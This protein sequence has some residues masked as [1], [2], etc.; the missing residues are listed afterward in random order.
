MKELIKSVL[1][2]T[3]YK[4]VRR[5]SATH[6]GGPPFD[7]EAHNSV[8][9]VNR[10]FSDKARLERY[11][12][13]GRRRLYQGTKALMV[14]ARP[15]STCRTV[16]DFGCGPGAFFTTFAPEFDHCELY[17]YDFAEATLAAAR[18]LCPRGVYEEY[19]IYTPPP[20]TH[21]MVVASQ[22]LEH[23]LEPELALRHLMAATAPGGVLV[24]TVPD[25]RIDT[26]RGHIHFWSPESWRAWI[27]RHVPG[28]HQTTTIAGGTMGGANLA[29]VIRL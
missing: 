18:T 13:P 6:G 24:L 25:G 22:I 11:V 19:D 16:G 29:A 5:E 14:D 15:P 26:Y 8:D 12:T 28:D 23:L 9:N 27:A 7:A 1:A 10:I 3:P 17:G 4:I 21:D 20:R 2:H